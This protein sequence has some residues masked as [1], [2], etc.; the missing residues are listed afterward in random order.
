MLK[1]LNWPTLQEMCRTFI[2]ALRHHS[3]N[4]NIAIFRRL[5][6]YISLLHKPLIIGSSFDKICSD[7]FTVTKQGTYSL[8]SFLFWFP[9]MK[10][11]IEPPDNKQG[12]PFR[13]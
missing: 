11:F 3:K 13:K 6:N 10:T 7:A 8:S 5:I 12:A 1:E 4:T 9:Y 2:S